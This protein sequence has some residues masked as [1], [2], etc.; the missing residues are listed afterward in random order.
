[1]GAEATL[2]KRCGNDGNTFTMM[3]PRQQDPDS[4][5]LSRIRKVAL[6]T[7]KLLDLFEA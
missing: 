3:L 7:P 5:G 1:M 6:V 4:L 2:G